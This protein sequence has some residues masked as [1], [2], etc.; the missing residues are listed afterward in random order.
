MVIECK[1]GSGNGSL[2][3]NCC[4]INM[5]GLYSSGKKVDLVNLH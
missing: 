2:D 5:M 1:G 3:I 4:A